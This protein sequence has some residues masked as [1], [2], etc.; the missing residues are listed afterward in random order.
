MT[1]IT[2][3][4]GGIIVSSALLIPFDVAPGVKFMSLTLGILGA[5][6]P[7][8]DR[9]NTTISNKIPILA[10]FIWV[11]QRF[12]WLITIPLPTK[13]KKQIRGICGHRGLTHSIAAAFLAGI[14]T[15]A[16]ASFFHSANY[17][18]YGASITIGSL[19]HLFLDLLSGK[20]PILLP[21]TLKRYQLGNIKTGG[22]TERLLQIA[23]LPFVILSI[24]KI[25]L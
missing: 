6:L 3:K 12:V 19:S 11:L 15:L 1:G 13:K 21:F 17:I 18:L 10:L 14:A 24:C 20:V 16:I 2:H 8:I 9:T 23:L 25:F 7:D 22:F 5:T 4:F